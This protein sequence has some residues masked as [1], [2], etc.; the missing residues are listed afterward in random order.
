M[1]DGITKGSSLK[2]LHG[3]RAGHKKKYFHSEGS[4]TLQPVTQKAC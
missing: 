2:L 4:M 3:V 1:E